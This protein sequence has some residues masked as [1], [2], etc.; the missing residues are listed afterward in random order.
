MRRLSTSNADALA[1]SR[2]DGRPTEL[3]SMLEY[4]KRKAMTVAGA[5]TPKVGLGFSLTFEDRLMLVARR[6]R[7]A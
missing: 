3:N 4:E 6:A 1:T 2:F 7:S 5:V